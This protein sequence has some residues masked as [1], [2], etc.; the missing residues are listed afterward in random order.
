MI[1]LSVVIIT[2][3]EEA[4]I[5]DCIR[6]VS[7]IADEV[8]VLDSFSTDNTGKI[9]EKLGG[10]FEQHTFDGH[11]QQKNRAKETAANDW[12]LSLDADE[13]P[14]ANLLEAIGQCKNNGFQ[15]DGYTMNRLNYYCGRP[16]RTCGWYPDT[17]LRLWNRRKGGWTGT[18]PHDRFEMQP[19][20]KILHLPGNL[21]HNTY[22]THEDMVRQCRKFARIA[23][24]HLQSKPWAYLIGKILFAA[25]SRFFRNYF[26][27]LG[28]TDGMA[29]WQI[30]RYQWLEVTLKYGLAMKM[31]W[32]GTE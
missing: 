4:S 21:L 8:L 14:D 3:N 2:Y 24:G 26:L 20:C 19:G 31:K 18:N 25:T 28:F 27:K 32:N 5:A 16:V 15:A 30:C 17:K 9:V 13:K 7:A 6:S 29:G 23:A 11:I 12:V 1:P 22:P 10:R